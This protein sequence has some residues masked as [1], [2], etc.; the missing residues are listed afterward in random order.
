MMDRDVFVEQFV[1]LCG[2]LEFCEYLPARTLMILELNFAR[3][4][5][6]EGET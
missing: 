2:Q 6:L 4:P 3:Q 5:L 1:S